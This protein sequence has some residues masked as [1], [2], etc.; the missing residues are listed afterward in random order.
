MIKK[1]TLIALMLPFMA[2]AQKNN[3]EAHQTN[4]GAPDL[5][6]SVYYP[7]E[8]FVS[9]N[10]HTKEALLNHLPLP[11]SFSLKFKKVYPSLT[12]MH[13]RYQLLHQG[14][15]VFMGEYHVAV[16]KNT[17]QV[18]LINH[19]QLPM[20]SNSDDASDVTLPANALQDGEQLL[21]QQIIYFPT[22]NM[23]IPAVYF[24]VTDEQNSHIARVYGQG[25]WLY[26]KDLHQYH[27]HA[28][29]NDTLIDAYVFNPDP[30]TSSGS[31]YGA[32]Y[33]D[34]N[35]NSVPVLEA[36]RSLQKVTMTKGTSGNIILENDAVIIEDF[37]SPFSGVTSGNSSDFLFTRDEGGFEDMNVLYHI[38]QQYLH[39]QNLGFTAYPGYQIRIDP[40]GANGQDNS[41]FSF[42]TG[43]TG[44]IEFGEGG[45]D[46][47]EDADVIVHEYNHALQ[48]AFTGTA[49]SS[50]ERGTIEEALADYFCVSYSRSIDPFNSDRVFGW[51]GHNEY[52]SGRE[53]KSNKNYQNLS[54]SG[55]IYTHTDLFVAALSEIYDS[56]GRNTADQV[57]WEAMFSLN[58]N[59]SMP[60]FA[61]H[62]LNADQNLN[63]G[64]NYSA[65]KTAYVRYGILSNT[66]SLT[67]AAEESRVQ[68]YAMEA[69][70]KGGNALVRIPVEAQLELYNVNGTLVKRFSY[71]EANS[72]LEIN[73]ADLKAG[74]YILKS[75]NSQAGLNGTAKLIRL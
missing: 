5:S 65:I 60:Q 62:S 59:T 39:L 75:I 41:F 51:D 27:H 55:N 18:Q 52:W 23:L 2:L 15:E 3:S 13:Y 14:K 7:T 38:N 4:F 40:H 9:I 31:T 6:N 33:V 53:G 67:E 45:V 74:V 19:T 36:E 28:G 69:F 43:S 8:A 48:R 25:Q 49:W 21:A 11:E 73:G 29:P 66:F 64:A 12:Q 58:P 68:V 42:G 47:A 35:D 71:S 1:H 70:A 37:A 61:I 16:N 56:L 54:F 20:Q 30:L 22:D 46:D 24:E 72:V 32:P 63:G 57:I 10:E 17:G 26:Q 34:N 50:V 44:T